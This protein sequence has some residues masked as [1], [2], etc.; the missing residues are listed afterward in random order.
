M[1]EVMG[2]LNVTPDSFS[3]GGFRTV[4][5]SVARALSMVEEGASWIDLGA[6][7][8]R[9]GAAP[10]SETEELDRLIP[11]LSRLATYKQHTADKQR[12]NFKISVDSM[13]PAVMAAALDEGAD[14][15][16]DVN[17]F[18][19]PGAWAVA[20]RAASICLMHMRG[21]P[22]T[23]QR[24]PDYAADEG[25]VVG[26]VRRFFQDQLALGM[27]HGL[28]PRRVILDP[29]IGFGKT[30]EHNLALLHDLSTFSRL[31]HHECR[32]PV[33]VGMSRKQLI[34]DITG[35]PVS[36]R[37]AGSVGAALAAY[38]NGASILRVHDVGATVD[39]LKVYARISVKRN[40][41]VQ[42]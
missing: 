19:A 41:G 40:E 29:G 14:M 10:V 24:A 27:S 12:V 16:N 35:K 3:D 18:R 21:R 42:G 15:L 38:A 5:E 20:V 11:V 39:A 22:E 8:T 7:S 37:M 17:G 26:A 30:T 9:P 2:V 31:D 4:D 23:M 28:D 1:A 25:G 13:K 6:E 32:F 33:L 36:E 34:G